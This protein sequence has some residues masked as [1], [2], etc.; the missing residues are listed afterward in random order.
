M[1][2]DV[3]RILLDTNI[4]GKIIEQND[5]DFVLENIAKSGIIVYGCDV[6]AKELRKVSKDKVTISGGKKKRLRNLI[7]GLYHA[8]VKKSLI[9]TDETYEIANLYY[10]TYKKLG[11][12]T[13]EEKLFTDFVI[14]ALASRNNLDIVYSADTET[15]LSYLSLKTYDI[16]NTIRKIRTP[17]FKKYGDFKNEIKMW[18]A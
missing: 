11:G 10:A 17:N 3:K 16:V 5:L 13:S 7:L 2:I 6:I 9:V 4:Y 8:L 15:M 14:V 1:V 18:C 12:A